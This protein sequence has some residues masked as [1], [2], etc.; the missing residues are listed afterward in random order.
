MDFGVLE[1]KMVDSKASDSKSLSI[2]GVTELMGHDT[3]WF[4]IKEALKANTNEKKSERKPSRIR[5]AN[6]TPVSPRRTLSGN[7]F[8]CNN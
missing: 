2:D 3:P 5:N 1:E 6:T 7:V 4:K 8:S